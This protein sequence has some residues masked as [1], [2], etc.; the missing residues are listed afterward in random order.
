MGPEPHQ[1]KQDHQGAGAETGCRR[2]P[3]ERADEPLSE[4]ASHEDA[5]AHARERDADRTASP[6]REPARQQHAH[7][8]R[9]ESGQPHG[10]DDAGVEI[11]LPGTANRRGQQRGGG[12]AADAGENHAAR[13]ES[14]DEEPSDRSERTL[15]HRRQGQR[16]G[17]QRAGPV[18]LL[19][20]WGKEHR[21][22]EIDPVRHR[23]RHPHD[24]DD[25]GARRGENG[26]GT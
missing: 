17:G 14:I 10:T 23:Q 3:A 11:K 18:E 21:E 26:A 7:R 24:D 2:A 15:H 25:R 8:H 1:R 22:R 9:A 5:S 6:L 13:A 20:Q 19:D 4:R 16:A 12:E